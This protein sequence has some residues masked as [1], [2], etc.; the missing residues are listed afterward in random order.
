MISYAISSVHKGWKLFAR[1]PNRRNLAFILKKL[2]TKCGEL[3][4]WELQKLVSFYRPR[5]HTVIDN[6]THQLSPILLLNPFPHKLSSGHC[7]V[8]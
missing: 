6:E 4:K 5:K 3:A 2:K 1:A 7:L 8:L